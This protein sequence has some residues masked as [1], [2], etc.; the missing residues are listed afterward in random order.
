MTDTQEPAIPH[1]ALLL[2]DY[3]ELFLKV[4]PD[5]AR[6]MRRS[7]FVAEVARLLGIPTAYTL[8]MPE[9]LG[10]LHEDFEG[11][12]PEAPQ[13]PKSS[14]S[15]F[16][17]EGLEEFIEEHEVQH[18]LIAGLETSIC[19]YQSAVEALGRDIDVTL[20]GDALDCRRHEDGEFALREIYRNGGHLLASESIFY[21]ILGDSSHPQFRDF[22]ALVKKYSD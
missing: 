6:L 4:M 11:L 22:T 1:L 14:F 10:G 2:V 16:G 21:S 17:A 5:R 13:F 19:I 18:L 8:Q 15:V 3:Q 12:Y 7:C 9:K 20:L